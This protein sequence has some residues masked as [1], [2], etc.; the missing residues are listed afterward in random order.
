M[1]D[2]KCEVRAIHKLC[3]DLCRL[4]HAENNNNSIC[5]NIADRHSEFLHA[6]STMFDTLVRVIEL[7]KCGVVGVANRLR[8]SSPSLL[9]TDNE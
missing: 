9:A 7:P 1:Y 4:A 3:Q 8:F 2:N 6:S 5:S